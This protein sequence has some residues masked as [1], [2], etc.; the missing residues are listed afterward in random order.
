MI[1]AMILSRFR[2]GQSSVERLRDRE[3]RHV[4]GR[5]RAV[6]GIN[7]R[8]RTGCAANGSAER[9]ADVAVDGDFRFEVVESHALHVPVRPDDFF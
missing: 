8:V 2:L 6:D 1:S 4:L 9:P 3:L 7:E 5:E